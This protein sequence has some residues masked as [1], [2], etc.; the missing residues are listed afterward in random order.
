MAVASAA[1]TVP[2]TVHK[3]AGKPGKPVTDKTEPTSPSTAD[4]VQVRPAPER[5][6]KLDAVPSDGAVAAQDAI[7]AAV[8]NTANVIRLG[9]KSF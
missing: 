6:A 1:C 7:G 2:V 9:E 4:P 5:A 8:S 3:T